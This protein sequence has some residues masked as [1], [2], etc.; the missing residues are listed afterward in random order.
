MTGFRLEI[1]DLVNQRFEAAG[2]VRR[3]LRQ[4]R[5]HDRAQRVNIRLRDQAFFLGQLLRRHVHRRALHLGVVT[6]EADVDVG[7]AEIHDFDLALVAQHDVAGFEVAMNNAFAVHVV[8]TL[9]ALVDDVDDLVRRQRLAAGDVF[10]QRH[11]VDEF[12]H[13][14]VQVVFLAGVVNADHRRVMH[15]PGA[16]NLGEKRLAHFCL[17]AASMSRPSARP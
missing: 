13:D 14:V 17:V 10:L 16:V 2:L 7:D 8:E 3:A 11:A 6:F 9:G 1:A 12:H 15:A 4:Q 5:V